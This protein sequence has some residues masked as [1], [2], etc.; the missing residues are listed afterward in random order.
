[1]FHDKL[2][3]INQNLTTIHQLLVSIYHRCCQMILDF[4]LN[5]IES[6]VS[7]SHS[8]MLN[9]N[10]N[11]N[12][13]ELLLVDNSKRVIKFLVSRIL[14]LSYTTLILWVLLHT[15]KEL[16]YE[17]HIILST[18]TKWERVNVVTHDT[19]AGDLKPVSIYHSISPSKKVIKL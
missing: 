7:N 18:R 2:Y 19:L 17:G 3:T 5:I 8:T 10:A 15:K 12:T 16:Q 6:Q 14:Y 4:F 9:G 11:T 13:L 1:M